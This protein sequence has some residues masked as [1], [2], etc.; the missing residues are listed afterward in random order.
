[1]KQA[2]VLGVLLI[3]L[4]NIVAADCWDRK[5]SID[6]LGTFTCASSCSKKGY[7]YSGYETYYKL[8]WPPRANTGKSSIS[9]CL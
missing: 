4:S 3:S 6:G 9:A 7:K 1:M 2:F 8:G 5:C